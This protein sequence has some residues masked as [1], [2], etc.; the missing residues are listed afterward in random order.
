MFVSAEKCPLLNI[1][2]S[3]GWLNKPVLCH[4]HSRRLNQVIATDVEA[5]LL[6]P[7]LIGR[8]RCFRALNVKFMSY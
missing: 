6:I 7:T 4:P 2:L 8:S 1:G 5:N 3:Q